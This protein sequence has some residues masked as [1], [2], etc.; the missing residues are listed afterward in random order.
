[1]LY[2]KVIKSEKC[3][4]ISFS[5]HVELNISPISE[6]DYCMRHVKQ[7]ESIVYQMINDGKFI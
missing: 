6:I 1:M 5:F 7:M 2:L 3:N 4:I